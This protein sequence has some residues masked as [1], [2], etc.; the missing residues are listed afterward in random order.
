MHTYFIMKKYLS[1]VLSTAQQSD[2][3]SCWV[4]IIE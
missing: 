2:Y 4:C 1:I 3:F